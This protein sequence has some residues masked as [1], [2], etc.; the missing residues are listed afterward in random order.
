MTT[1]TSNEFQITTESLDENR[2]ITAGLLQIGYLD[3]NPMGPG[4][5]NALPVITI[6]SE[7]KVISHIAGIKTN[8]PA[9]T[10]STFIRTHH[11]KSKKEFVIML[12]DK[13]QAT[14]KGD[15][16][17]TSEGEFDCDRVVA[18]AAAIREVQAKEAK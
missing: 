12:N 11:G 14:L 6:N 4:T 18:L 3:N 5:L 2:A 16:V 1:S 10:L 15:V 13:I 9:L 8:V 7:T 17:V